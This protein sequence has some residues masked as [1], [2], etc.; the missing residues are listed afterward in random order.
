MCLTAGKSEPDSQYIPL[1]AAK[2]MNESI[3]NDIRQGR[4]LNRDIIKYI[5]MFTMTLNHLSL[6][7]FIGNYELAK[8][9]TYIGYFT[10][11]TMT[12]F[13]VEGFAYTR[14]RMKYGR[15]LL[16]FAVLSEAPFLYALKITPG[17]SF[18]SDQ[19][20]LNVIFNLFFCFL[21]LTTLESAQTAGM[22]ILEIAVL[23]IGSAMSDWS[24]MAPAFTLIFYFSAH[25]WKKP[26]PHMN[27]IPYG[28]ARARREKIG[29]LLC[30]L[31][32][33]ICASLMSAVYLLSLRGNGIDILYLFDPESLSGP[34]LSFLVICF[35]YSGKRMRHAKAFSKWF[36]YIYYPAHLAIIALILHLR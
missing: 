30:L 6:T 2:D 23:F 24:V 12:Y 29:Y 9:F 21:I 19:V 11:I 36:F 33:I 15:R 13:L 25:G 18:S 8:Q 7:G 3:P 17:E 26:C 20:E 5:A 31:F 16:L 14:D 28:T 1:K 27:G 35:L 22:K 32:F 4:P 34:L 10:L